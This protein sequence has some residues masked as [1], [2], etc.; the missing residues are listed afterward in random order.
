MQIDVNKVVSVTYSLEVNDGGNTPKVFVEEAKADRPL[1][2][3]F[4]VGGMI[5]GF[6]RAME[7]LRV[8][9]LFDFSIQ[10]A[11]AYGDSS[12]DDVVELPYSV[13]EEEVKKYPDLL[14]IGNIIP[15]NDGN[16]H[17]FEGRVKSVGTD[18]VTM[19]FN[20]PLAGKT[21]HFKGRVEDLRDASDEEIAHGHAHGPGGHHH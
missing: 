11:D 14:N 2:F 5:P 9:D 6:E 21:L 20:H 3:L 8:G 18:T 7:G 4:G 12:D 15:M 19:D 16:G 1:V 13:F 17:Q 10:P